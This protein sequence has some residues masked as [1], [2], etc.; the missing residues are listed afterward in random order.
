VPLFVVPR[1]G[2]STLCAVESGRLVGVNPLPV[3]VLAESDISAEGW[4]AWVGDQG[5]AIGRA[6]GDAEPH[7]QRFP[8][9]ILPQGCRAQRG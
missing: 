6:H 1:R 4:V 2:V 8:P 5:R 7:E 3:P 9:I